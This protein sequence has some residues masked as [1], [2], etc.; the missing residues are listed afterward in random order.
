MAALTPAIA[1]FLTQHIT[2][3]DELEILMLLVQ[4]S[5]RW[6]D[7]TMITRQLGLSRERAQSALDALAV[8]N[9]LDIRVS[10]DVRYQFRPGRPDL[11][12]AALAVAEAYRRRSAIIIQVVSVAA[13]RVGAH[14]RGDD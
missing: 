12:Q 4:A 2:S 9:L 3:V 13:H 1:E 14:H 11:E 8:Q 10:G 6:F 5:T 7:A